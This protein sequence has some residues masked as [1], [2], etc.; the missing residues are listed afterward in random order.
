M[1]KRMREIFNSVPIKKTRRQILMQKLKDADVAPLDEQKG[2]VTPQQWRFIKE[3]CDEEG[4]ITLRQ[5][6]INAGYPKE[7]AHIIANQLTAPKQYPQ[8]VR[9]IQDYRYEQA[10]KYG[11]NFERHMRDLQ[12]I[13][14]KALEAGNYGAAVSAEFRRGQALGSIYIEKKVTLTGSI[15]SMPKEEVRRKL[16]EL[17]LMHGSRVAPDIL[18]ITPDQ[19]G[20]DDAEPH[21]MLE[22]MRDGERTRRLTPQAAEESAAV[23]NR[24]TGEPREPGATGLPGSL[25]PDEVRANRAQS[26]DQGQESETV[27]APDSIRVESLDDRPADVH[28][29][30]MASESDE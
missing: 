16:E 21:T 26:G 7:R 8:V 1:S 4:K 6:A 12:V 19:L 20:E 30:R 5:A 11:T 2:V 23:F 25:A 27:P 9:A 13:R 24:E 14:D 29:D 22:A 28:S 10:E 17:K 15:D 18:D 3:L